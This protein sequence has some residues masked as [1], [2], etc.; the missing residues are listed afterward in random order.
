LPLDSVL[1]Y[2]SQIADALAHA[3]QR[4][5][6]HRDLK[7][8]NVM[9][10]ADGRVKVLD[11]GL[12]CGLSSSEIE[13]ATRSKTALSSERVLAGTLAYMAPELFRAAPA[14]ART[15]LWSLGVVLY[16]MATGR[17]PFEGV[18]AFELVSA[19]L[20]QP[21]AAFP[22]HIPASLQAVI[23]RCL[24][25]DPRERYAQAGEVGA[26]AE[27]VRAQLAAGLS[28]DRGAAQSGGTLPQPRTSFIGRAD[29][30]MRCA[31]E[32]ASG[33][34]LTLTGQGKRGA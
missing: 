33:R 5:L 3:H 10:T 21:P 13:E 15:D 1:R 34:M 24:A 31:R 19:I 7:S 27:T 18:T 23:R 26:A 4:G 12:A 14:D 16:E 11:F 2:G 25:K 22:G 6:V 20:H 28:G 8:A 32:L 29:D 9:I 30:L 17:L